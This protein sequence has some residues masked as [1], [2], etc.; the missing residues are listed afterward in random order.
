MKTESESA[1]TDVKIELEREQFKFL[2]ASNPNYFGN[3]QSSDLKPVKLIA[4]NTS[5][6]ELHC[7]GFHQDRDL[8][9][10]TLHIK[11]AFGYKGSLCQPGSTEYVR[12]YIDYGSGWE[13]VG[14]SS[15]NVHDIPNSLDCAERATKPLIYVVTL[16][17][18]PKRKICK[19]P[20]L[21][22]VRAI[23]SWETPPPAATPAWPPVWGNVLERSIQI[24]PRAPWVID[25][26][27][28]ISA[29]LGKPIKIPPLFEEVKFKPIPL[30]DPAPDVLPLETLA[31]LYSAGA[32]TTKGAVAADVKFSVEPHRF[33]LPYLQS[34]LANGGIDQAGI[35]SNIQSWAKLGL[36]W[37][38]ALKA[39]DQTKADVSYG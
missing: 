38:S 26:Y 39:L 2:L 4:S 9:E 25:I 24:K 15:V 11:R 20:V 28:D 27:D 34:A 3:L 1:S 13:D 14:V 17:L 31:N 16:A 10:A 21:P 23:L 8:I 22:K 5:Y 18:D 33:A 35:V 30:P 12:F 6:E 19:I 29:T 32:T 7:I 37:Q 36:D